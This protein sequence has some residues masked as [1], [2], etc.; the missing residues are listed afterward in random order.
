MT[1]NVP[2]SLGA[3]LCAVAMIALPAQAMAGTRAGDSRN[4]EHQ[5]WSQGKVHP[6][7]DSRG[8]RDGFPDNHGIAEA[9]EHADDHAPFKSN[10]C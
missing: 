3:G 6:G 4:Y 8:P 1:R 10:G 7:Y 2:L 9:R 5:Q